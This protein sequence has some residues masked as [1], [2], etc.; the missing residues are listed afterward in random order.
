[1]D[2]GCAYNKGTYPTAMLQPAS[3][4]GEGGGGGLQGYERESES[5]SSA[6]VG[7]LSRAPWGPPRPCVSGS[8]RG[9]T[10]GNGAG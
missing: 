4:S 9:V 5:G 7:R 10:L 2:E 6:S 3:K 8:S 1:M